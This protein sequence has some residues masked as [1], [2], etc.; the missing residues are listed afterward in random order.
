MLLHPV[1]YRVCL[2]KFILALEEPKNPVP[3]AANL[4][5]NPKACVSSSGCHQPPPFIPR[6]PLL[7]SGPSNKEA[8]AQAQQL[9]ARGSF[10]STKTQTA[11]FFTVVVESNKVTHLLNGN[12]LGDNG[13]MYKLHPVHI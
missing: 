5:R 11:V 10:P 4:H 6:A 12:C 1:V 2:Q 3:R 7:L 13:G 9:L 8:K